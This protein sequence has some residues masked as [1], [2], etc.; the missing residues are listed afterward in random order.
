VSNRISKKAVL[1]L[2]RRARL[3]EKCKQK[4]GGKS[5]GKARK[6]YMCGTA[7]RHDSRG[8]GKPVLVYRTI[9]DFENEKACSEE[10]GL[11]EVEIRLVRWVKKGG[12]G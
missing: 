9:H 3:N 12:A 1:A 5:C 6:M 10:C 11:V 2:F 7:W 4:P 8:S